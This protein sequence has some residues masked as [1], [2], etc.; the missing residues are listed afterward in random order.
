MGLTTPPSWIR[1]PAGQTFTAALSM[2]ETQL[3][4]LA[5]FNFTTLGFN[6]GMVTGGGD[7]LAV[8]D[9]YRIREIEVTIRPSYT[10]GFASFAAPTV[11]TVIDLDD[12]NPLTTAAAFREYGNVTLSQYETVVRKWVPRINLPA[13]ISGGANTGSIPV[14]APWIDAASVAV[15]HHGIKIGIDGNSGTPNAQQVT[16][17]ARFLIDFRT[18]R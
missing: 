4:S 18:T 17:N 8:F 11:Y 10:A 3:V 1:R 12:S 9:A 5:A 6:M 7:Y 15:E 14:P 16:I 2:I 13:Y